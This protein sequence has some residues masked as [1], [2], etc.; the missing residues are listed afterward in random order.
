MIQYINPIDELR[1]LIA[2]AQ[3]VVLW[4]K[5]EKATGCRVPMAM[6]QTNNLPQGVKNDEQR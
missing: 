3:I 6:L 2:I 1:S 4:Y 5:K